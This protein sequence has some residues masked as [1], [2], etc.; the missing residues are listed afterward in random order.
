MKNILFTV[1]IFIVL[2]GCVESSETKFEKD[3]VTFTCPAGW[4]I[5]D[6]EAMDN[7]GYFISIEKDGF[8]SSGLFTMTYFYDSLD[9]PNFIEVYKD[10][11][12]EQFIYK[13][14]NLSFEAPVR[15]EFNKYS[16]I[17]SKYTV[18]IL[19]VEHQGLIHVLHGNNKTIALII[20]EAVEDKDNNRLGF[21]SIEQS[22][23][24]D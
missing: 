1:L 22:F 7:K 19:N 9:L 16:S 17:S 5:V 10:G 15:D 23:T 3:G 6:E 2:T 12:T 11:F 13:N 8:S 18:S 20:Q 14:S 24:L 21:D 4:K